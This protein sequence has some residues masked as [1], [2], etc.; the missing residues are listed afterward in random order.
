[1]A[2]KVSEKPKW[3]DLSKYDSLIDLS[4]I[5]WSHQ[6]MA[7]AAILGTYQTNALRENTDTSLNDREWFERVKENPILDNKYGH[8]GFAGWKNFKSYIN[9]PY[10]DLY[11]DYVVPLTCGKAYDV[12]SGLQ[13]TIIS[14]LKS[15]DEDGRYIIASWPVDYIDLEIGLEAGP[16]VDLSIDLT[17]PNEKII[18]NFE[19]FLEAAR[20]VY[21]WPEGGEIREAITNR[22]I[23]NSILPYLDLWIWWKFEDIHISQHKLGEWLFTD[24][25][26]NVTE[27]LRRSTIPLAKRSITPGFLKTLVEL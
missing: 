12:V 4:P 17:A 23:N 3:F 15:K 2:E 19:K 21:Q 26:I 25:I 13:P 16:I 11:K 10:S 8:K 20:E 9:G 6:L 5:E 18:N 22:L 14:A 1:M 24:E 27:K 7:R